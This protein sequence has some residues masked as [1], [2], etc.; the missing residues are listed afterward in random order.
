MRDD[1]GDC[2]PLDR[3]WIG[4]ERLDLDLET[5]VCGGDDAVALRLVV[6][7]AARDVR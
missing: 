1:R 3:C 2:E 7:A 5:G 6:R 4:V